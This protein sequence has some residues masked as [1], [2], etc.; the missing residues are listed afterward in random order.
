MATNGGLTGS[1]FQ[2]VLIAAGAA[3][4]WGLEDSPL[5]ESSLELEFLLLARGHRRRAVVGGRPGVPA[6]TRVPAE[7]CAAPA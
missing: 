1:L 4:L 6:A 2:A 7:G 3:V 5:P